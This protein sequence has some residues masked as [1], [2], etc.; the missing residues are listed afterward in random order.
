MSGLDVTTLAMAV[1]STQVSSAA[2]ALDKMAAAGTKAETASARLAKAS[3][4]QGRTLSALA[5]AANKSA[6]AFKS[7]A[8]AEAALGPAAAKQLAAAGAF[9]A[10][11]TGAT[12][13]KTAVQQLGD[14]AQRTALTWR[15]FLG[16]RMGPA[17]R[18]LSEQGVPHKDAHT[19]AIRQIA[20]EWQQYK[21]AGVTAQAAVAAQAGTTTA[22]ITAMG[23]AVQQAGAKTAG[24]SGGL[25]A[26]AADAAQAK[27]AVT[28]LS[29]ATTSLGASSFV[30][31]DKATTSLGATAAKADEAAL[32]VHR[33]QKEI[34]LVGP[35]A[36]ATTSLG[37]VTGPANR[38]ATGLRGA[39]ER[40]GQTQI[41]PRLAGGAAGANALAAAAGKANP[42]VDA[43]GKTTRLAAFQQQQ[44]GFQVH[45]FFVQIA[46]G[47][48]PLTAFIQQGS[49]LS[50]TFGG[51]GNAL[52]AVTSLITP[53][54]A[55]IAGAAATVGGLVLVLARAESAAR[56][57][58]TVQ[59]QLAGTGREGMFSTGELRAF[60]NELAKAPGVTRE[61]ATAIVSELSK[62]HD[63]GGGIFKDLGRI[64]ADYAKATGTDVPAA[65][66]TL[67]KAF[68][69][70]E[71]GVK[72]LDDALGTISSTTILTV[73]RLSK[74]GDTASA[75]RVL[76]DALNG[77]LKG[78]ADN[79][80]T[81]LQKSVNDLGNSWASATDKLSQS[82]GL[83]T[84]N[85]LL[86][87][88]VEFVDFLVRN[89][90]KVGGIGNFALTMVP[91]VGLPAAVANAVTG[92]F[93][94]QTPGQ[95]EVKGRVTDLTGLAA[96]GT[97]GNVDDEIKRAK[98]AARTYR[99]QAGEL[100][101]LGAERK[102]FNSAL[103]KSVAL[104][105]KE[106]EQAKLF[107]QAIAGVNERMASVR[108]RGAGG[109]NE[110]QQVLDAQLEQR[111]KASRDILERERDDMAF[112]Q[113]YL[114]G[115]FHS[116]QISLTDFY[117]EKRATIAR[118]VAAE[119]AELDKER[120]AVEKHL[121]DT[122]RT[123]PKDLSAQE[124]DR[125]RLKDIEAQG[126]KIRLTGAREAV[127]A[128]QQQAEALRQL[129]EQVL[130]YRAELLQLQGDEI[131]AA[132]VRAQIA[133]SQ[134][135]TLA[136]QSQR[137]ESPITP[138]DLAAYERAIDAQNRLQAARHATS[139]VNDILVQEEERIALALRT[140]AIGEIEAME[141]TGAARA[142]VAAQLEEIV[143]AQEEIA[144]RAENSQ[145]WQLQI[146]TSRARLELE[147]LKAELDPLKEKFDGMFKDAGAGFF[148]DLM[149]GAKPKDAL[150][151]FFGSVGREINSTV[152][153]E[154]SGQIFGKDG[155]LGGAGGFL[156]SIFGEKGAA[157]GKPSVDTSAVQQAFSALRAAGIDPATSALA[158]L[159]V[160]ADAAA[161]S[162][163]STP[164]GTPPALTTGDFSRF[165]RGQTGEGVIAGMFRDA[166]RGNEEL[167]ENSAEAAS[168]LMQFAN[169]AIK[170]QG[171]LSQLPAVIQAIIA[172][173]SASSASGG[174]GILGS[175]FSLFGGGG[176]NAGG[177]VATDEA[178]ALF[179][180]SGG[181]VGKTSDMRPV[182]RGVFADAG[183]YHV[184]GAVGA[185]VGRIGLAVNEVPA[186]LMGGPKGVREEVLT[187]KDPR[188]RDRL[189]PELAGAIAAA[190]R[191]HT[192]G[193][194]GLTPDRQVDVLKPVRS[195]YLNASKEGDGPKPKG[196]DTYLTVQVTATPGMTHD[197]VMN[198]GR[199]IGRQIQ[200]HARRRARD[201]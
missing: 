108:K 159:Q 193:I 174:G 30:N 37:A 19:A 102:R 198:Q 122:I 200:H 117:E 51:A 151:S 55:A 136:A 128:D 131:G 144:A 115:V 126:D 201:N 111:L 177:T 130:N 79:T 97:D 107:R 112:Q 83:R 147:K 77:S 20:A 33:L 192:G 171:A 68:A 164:S 146:D 190:P 176:G 7:L 48:N 178:L 166:R 197:Q 32:A 149:N 152:A 91:G 13:A 185:A 44:L 12:T 169:A 35:L 124:R 138:Q 100:A 170:G 31:F 41:D 194:A 145:N 129:S 42:L 43:L 96:A 168:A 167:R 84:L 175:I 56:D 104:Y 181:I 125:T 66:K 15:E 99:G 71:R 89:A 6:L 154:L 38:P 59:A 183:R 8:E 156:A 73:E 25:A 105:G 46:S 173:A 110:P 90:D 2:A 141:R 153:K 22:A 4:D 18:E 36:T 195:P 184:G 28:D 86:S 70:P 63:I 92:P 109:G 179:F 81:P 82:E 120:A 88:T 93:R 65:A 29:K 161:G 34:A 75:Q 94:S 143:R 137:S 3:A 24:R 106:S 85:N 116:G 27:T 80:M 1:D 74:L 5:P 119:L 127:L 54:R 148:E 123:S 191:Y 40:A 103:E 180:H 62:V 132:K 155:A 196:G 135:K 114:Q 52:R 133:Q 26:M 118:G 150:K 45:D 101:D 14:Q 76:I 163:G 53:M 172:S 78:L 140:G 95:R 21:V 157:A 188:H 49:Q 186:I 67:A 50:G 69:D 158:R 162:I 17:M 121:A 113:R 60:I 23:N 11:A 134:L 187:A 47:S 199:E 165:D 139:Q 72:Q 182:P 64:T 160:A 39:I 57:L 10:V 58:A 9:D 61:T 98:E 189:T 142:K 16:Q 87:K